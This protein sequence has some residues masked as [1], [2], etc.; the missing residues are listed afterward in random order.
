[1]INMDNLDSKRLEKSVKELSELCRHLDPFGPIDSK[2]KKKLKKFGLDKEEDPFILT[3]K[4]IKN[5]EDAMSEL[6]QRKVH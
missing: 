2:M 1:M 4:L 6:E 3:N 5:L